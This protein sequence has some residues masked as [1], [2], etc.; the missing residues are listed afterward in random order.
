VIARTAALWL[1]LA[2]TSHAGEI[3]TVAEDAQRGEFLAVPIPQVDPALGTGLVGA[4][5]YIFK[6][7]P[8]DE[9][10]PPSILGAGALW[11]DGG[12]WGGG[13]GGKFYL[14]EDRFRIMAGGVF[15]DLRYDLTVDS[16]SATSSTVPLG[17]EGYGGLAHAQFRI[18]PHTYLGARAQFGKLG[19]TLRAG[20]PSNLPDSILE[21]IG[22]LQSVNSLGPSFAFDT[23]DSAYY[24]RHGIALDADIS[25]HFDSLGSDVSMNRYE[26]NYRQYRP[27]RDRDV[28][29]WQAYAC[30]TE[31]DVP[32]YME[33]QVGQNSLLRGYSF[34]EYRGNAM[35]AAQA[36][37]RWQ[38]RPRW[39]AAAFAGVTQV[40]PE[41][42]AFSMAENLYAGG[43]GLRFVVEPNNGV[44]LRVDYGVGKDE[45]A[46]YVSVGEAF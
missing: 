4:A 26:V 23:R 28:F 34:G 46:I 13:L 42:G 38:F 36:E 19:T 2:I 31:G 10:S 33:C 37:Y 20:D 43:V 14:R 25:F 27:L 9:V 17:Q 3:P 22:L 1:A 30:A 35:I 16:G 32:F 11:M 39:I 24:P 45:D 41:F 40:A 18:A 8:A 12:S 29:A 21:E 6:L 7:N 15:A 44:T 5:A